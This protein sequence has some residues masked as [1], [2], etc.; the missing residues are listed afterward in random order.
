LPSRSAAITFD[1][2]YADNHDVAMPILQRHGLSATFFIAT[3]Y[4]DGGLMF[5]D[6]VVET[7]R[8]AQ[9]PSL[10]LST[11]LLGNLGTHDLRTI[12]A[13]RAAVHRVLQTLRHFPVEHRTAL[14]EQ[15]Q[16]IAGVAHLPSDL[17]LRSEQVRQMHREGMLLG[18]HTVRHPMLARLDAATARSELTQSR[19]TLQDLLGVRVTLFAYP[20]GR[21]NE[22]YSAQTVDLVRA[23]GFDAAFTTA[24][25]VARRGSDAHQLPRFTPWDRSRGRF[26]LRMAVNL[27]RGPEQLVSLAP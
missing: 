18:A 21:P 2:G 26:G 14:C 16:Q 3:G 19:D 11:T 27:R 7:L 10:D 24:W 5:N 1:D 15:L 17:M 9:G 22:D 25:G 13:R 6:G 12:E 8:R 4:L 23:A 20:N